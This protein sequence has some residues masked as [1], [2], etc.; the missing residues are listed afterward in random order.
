MLPTVVGTILFPRLTALPTDEARWQLT[1]RA[2]TGLGALMLFGVSVA[3]VCAPFVV[4]ILYGR[5]FLPAI[6]AVVW[7]MP[8]L[9]CL[10]VNIVFMN[11]FGS[12]GMPPIAVLSPALAGDCPISHLI[13]CLYR[14][15]ASWAPPRRPSVAY[16]LMLVCSSV[17]SAP[18]VVGM[19]GS[20]A[21]QCAS[22]HIRVD[23]HLDERPF[24][25]GRNML[26]RNATQQSMSSTT[27]TFCAMLPHSMSP[28]H[29]LPL[30]FENQC[31]GAAATRSIAGYLVNE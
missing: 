30:G 15:W 19:N 26:R 2:L 17:L 27:S 24:E 25:S 8:G 18:A 21:E 6:P 4:R 23:L 7:L 11:Y 20:S 5:Q 9:A 1:R 12:I 31:S 14:E 3:A 29:H 13:L 10:S 16:A 28:V 22:G